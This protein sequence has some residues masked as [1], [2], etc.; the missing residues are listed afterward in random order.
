MRSNNRAF[1]K[2]G[3]IGASLRCDI[4]ATLLLLMEFPS[5]SPN[6]RKLKVS[7]VEAHS[8]NLVS[9]LLL[10]ASH[11]SSVPRGSKRS[12]SP[13]LYRFFFLLLDLHVDVGSCER[14]SKMR[15]PFQY[16]GRIVGVHTA[17]LSL[18]CPT[19]PNRSTQFWV[20]KICPPN[21]TFRLVL[22]TKEN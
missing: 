22:P 6:E 17:S 13:T 19:L 1:S 18:S 11:C 14:R 16:G 2:F 5:C 20:Q 4:R 12:L 8:R 9:G 15:R 10:S 21:P 3:G 7:L